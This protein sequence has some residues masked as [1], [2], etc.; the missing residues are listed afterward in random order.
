MIFWN[1]LESEKNNKKSI[2][3]H[4]ANEHFFKIKKFKK[5][6]ILITKKTPPLHLLAALYCQHDMNDDGS[7]IKSIS[8]HKI[9]CILIFMPEIHPSVLISNFHD[10]VDILLSIVVI[11]SPYQVFNL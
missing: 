6:S 2:L 8:W 1:A 3:E 10:A 9:N 7:I 4:M 5:T 11:A